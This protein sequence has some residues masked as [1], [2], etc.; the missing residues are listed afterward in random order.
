M[1]THVRAVSC[2]G[3]GA[4]PNVYLEVDSGDDE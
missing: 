1:P 2:E 4:K 3:A